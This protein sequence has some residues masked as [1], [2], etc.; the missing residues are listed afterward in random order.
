MFGNKPEKQAEPALDG[1]GQPYVQEFE[2]E[3]QA[4][5][6]IGNFNKA[7]NTMAAAGWELINGGMAGTVHYGYFRRR[8]TQR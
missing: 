1:A 5:L 8:L 6:G 7:A 2:Y 3:A 4:H